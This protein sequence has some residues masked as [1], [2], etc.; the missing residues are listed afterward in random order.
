MLARARRQGNQVAAL[1]LD[2]DNFKD[3]NDTLG[4]EAGDELLAA[5]ANRMASALRDG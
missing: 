3:I 1:F 5:V 4:H 2:L